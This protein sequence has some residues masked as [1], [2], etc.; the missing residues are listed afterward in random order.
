MAVADVFGL[1]RESTIDRV[2]AEEAK[3]GKDTAP[4]SR[5]VYQTARQTRAA[6]L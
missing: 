1:V 5:H 4:P 2:G 3:V 6:G